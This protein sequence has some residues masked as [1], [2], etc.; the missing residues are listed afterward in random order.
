MDRA[1]A[2]LSKSTNISRQPSSFISTRSIHSV[3]S[4][5]VTPDRNVRRESMR[6][7]QH[8]ELSFTSSSSE[9]ARNSPTSLTAEHEQRANNLGLFYGIVAE[10]KRS[11]ENLSLYENRCLVL[12]NSSFRRV[13]DI[14]SLVLLLYVALFT[15]VQIAFYGD[16]MSMSNWEEWVFVF[17]LDRIVDS[18]KLSSSTKADALSEFIF[19]SF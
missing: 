3:S 13:W 17:I 8:K 19:L 18:K 1:A 7:E 4:T 11:D 15:P 12:P 16:T 6:G 5:K 9:H 10:A 14:V 2:G